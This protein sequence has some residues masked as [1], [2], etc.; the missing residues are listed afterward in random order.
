MIGAVILVL[1]AIGGGS[2]LDDPGAAAAY[3]A[4]MGLFGVFSLMVGIGLWRLRNWARI[5]AVVLYGFSAAIGLVA[6][7]QGA[8]A[9]FMQMLVASSIAAY[10]CRAYARGAFKARVN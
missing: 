10:L 6:L 8:P 7:C 1:A 2:E 4:I 9:G 5:A 3:G